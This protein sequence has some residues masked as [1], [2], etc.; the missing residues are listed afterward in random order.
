MPSL[1]EN[2]PVAPSPPPVAPSQ[3]GS[4]TEDGLQEG[5]RTKAVSA[6]H[7]LR[8]GTFR[9]TE[10]NKLVNFVFVPEDFD[11]ESGD[12]VGDALAALGLT[13]PDIAFYF[14]KGGKLS[15]QR[16]V[17]QRV[18]AVMDG[19]SA[20]C[21]QTHSIY[22]IR[23]PYE[24]NRLAEIV[25]KSAAAAGEDCPIL[26]LF[27]LGNLTR[28]DESRDA[29]VRDAAFF[30]KLSAFTE[31]QESKKK[32]KEAAK[33]GQPEVDLGPEPED[34]WPSVGYE[35]GEAGLPIF[36]RWDAQRVLAG[37]AVL[38]PA[39]TASSLKEVSITIDVSCRPTAV[40][41]A[42]AEATGGM[43]GLAMLDRV[44]H[45][46]VFADHDFPLLNEKKNNAAGKAK[47]PRRS[48]AEG[49]LQPDVTMSSST[50]KAF[51]DA[52]V[53]QLPTGIISAGG[54]KPLFDSCIDCLRLGRPVFCFRGTGGSTETIAKLI[55]FGNLKKGR[56]GRPGASPKQLEN[57]IA[58]EFTAESK[59]LYWREAKALACNFPEHFNP[60][61]ALV[62]EVG[63]PDGHHKLSTSPT[64]T[65]IPNPNPSPNS[66]PNPN[67]NPNPNLCLPFQFLLRQRHLAAHLSGEG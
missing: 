17:D 50:Q 47:G 25:C 23:Q 56:H 53:E 20:A 44:T 26:G 58:R 21:A 5:L 19:I 42:M 57:F 39:A 67:P 1:A 12:V 11:P 30:E 9:I 29:D 59:L 7:T 28:I 22:M 43:T 63:A 64:S 15:E 18:N 41:R 2:T 60:S 55:D 10:T 31:Y 16:V 40:E 34:P 37:D 52:V 54:T 38:N 48:R 4:T 65:P 46:I 24:G 49:E 35:D 61:A 32:N 13:R 8:H 66:N 62:I 27:H 14:H 33:A 6:S 3:H 51:A 36:R 45:A